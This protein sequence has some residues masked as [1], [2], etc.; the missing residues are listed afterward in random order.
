MKKLLTRRKAN[1]VAQ[2]P[3][4]DIVRGTPLN[5]NA[6][7][8]TRYSLRL[9]A[10]IRSMTI[11]TERR[12]RELFD[13]EVGSEY[14]AQDASIASQTR[15]LVN[16]LTQKYEKLFSDIA[17]PAAEQFAAQADAASSAAMHSS[18]RELSGGLS[19][20]T[21]ALKGPAVQI[22]KATV[23]E[24]VLLIKSIPEKYLNGVGQAVQRSIT[25]GNGLADLVPYLAKHKEITLNRATLIA[26]DQTR[27]AFNNLNKARMERLGLKK[28]EWLHTGGSN[29][30]RELH[31]KYSGQIFSFDNLPIIDE[32]TKE[33]GIP[34]QA[35]NCRCR[36]VPV[37]DLSGGEDD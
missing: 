3:S 35:I 20:P 12:L 5:P 2:R 23:N 10:A 26:R 37:I 22:M 28:F 21:A 36:M 24:N 27:K 7:I 9:Q 14:F 17:V 25:T 30:P 4:V 31:V 11:E 19:L 16:A 18:L 34:G 32:N 1:W 29:E 13:S 8:S 15:I 33:R 6:A